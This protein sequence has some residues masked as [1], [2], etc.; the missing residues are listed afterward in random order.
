MDAQDGPRQSNVHAAGRLARR[1]MWRAGEKKGSPETVRSKHKQT[2]SRFYARAIDDEGLW[3]WKA[4][5]M[6]KDF[7]AEEY[8]SNCTKAG[9]GNACGK[10]L[11]CNESDQDAKLSNAGAWRRRREEPCP[12]HLS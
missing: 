10:C 11:S 2:R 7:K 3:N 1:L 4:V 5:A 8:K 6:M 9:Q 12:Q